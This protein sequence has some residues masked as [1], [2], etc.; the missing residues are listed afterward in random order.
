MLGRGLRSQYLI[1]ILQ[2]IHRKVYKPEMSSLIC[3]LIQLKVAKKLR[4]NSGYGA[5]PNMWF[6]S[7][8]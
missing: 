4:L 6:L 3:I 2:V 5:E 8:M 7:L 1:L